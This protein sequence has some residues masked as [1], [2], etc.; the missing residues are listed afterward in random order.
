[1]KNIVTLMIAV[2]LPA[3]MAAQ[4]QSSFNLDWASTGSHCVIGGGPSLEFQK[5]AFNHSA[6]RGEK[7][8][9]QAVISSD[10]DLKDVTLSVSDL[11]NGK[12]VISSGNITLQ[13]VSFVVS[14]L[15]DTTRYGQCGSREDKSK[16]GEVLVADVLDI[17]ESIKVPAGRRQPVWMT[18]GV[19]SDAKPGK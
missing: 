13:F 3:L 19:P 7:V 8:F 4:P 6:W 12:S 1:M 15:L 9:A 18:V 2:V 16:W 11:R 5:K 10:S 17:A 14:D